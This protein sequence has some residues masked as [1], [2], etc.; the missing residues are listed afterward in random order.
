MA[1]L[2]D[3]GEFGFISELKK[4]LP[5]GKGVLRGIGDDTAVVRTPKGKDTLFTTDMLVE[6]HHFR[7]GEASGFEVGWKALAVNISDIAAMGGVPTFA[8]VAVGFPQALSAQFARDV[9]EGL[10]RCAKAFGVSIVGGDTNASEKIV[11]SAS[12][13]GEVEKGKAVLRSGAKMGDV[14]FVSGFLGGSY[15]SRRHLSFTPRLREARFLCKKFKINAMMDLSDGLSSDIRRL[16]E[17]SGVGAVLSKENIPISRDANGLKAALCEGEDFELL[18]TVSPREAARLTLAAKDSKLA[19]FHPVG[20]IV[21]KK[22]GV[23]L[24]RDDRARE[25]LSAEGFDHYLA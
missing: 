23:C 20:R 16:T 17:E 18:F 9:Y 1:T 25:P 6:D 14:I 13:L 2:G 3:L 15:A 21:D 24:I 12:L 10:S 5:A 4:K 7:L 8:V 11:V 22:E 19:P